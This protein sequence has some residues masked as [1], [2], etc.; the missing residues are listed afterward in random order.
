MRNTGVLQKLTQSNSHT[1]KKLTQGN[2]CGVYHVGHVYMIAGGN[3]H[4]HDKH[5][6]QVKFSTKGMLNTHMVDITM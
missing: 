4:F 1:Q 2:T 3:I 6:A 5:I